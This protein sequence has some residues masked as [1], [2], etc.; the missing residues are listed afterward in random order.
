MLGFVGKADRVERAG[1]AGGR[2]QHTLAITDAVA[3]E[4][5]TSE[6]TA[7]YAGPLEAVVRLL[8]GRLGE[9]SHAGRKPR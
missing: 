5:G 8:G 9:D 7:T 2:G 6:T 3:L 1:E 4:S